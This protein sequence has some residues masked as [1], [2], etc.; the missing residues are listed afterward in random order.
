MKRKWYGVYAFNGFGIYTNYQKLINDRT[1]MRGEHIK[2]FAEQEE[3][4]S[5]ATDGFVEL[6]G[7]NGMDSLLSMV[8]NIDCLRLNYFYFSNNKGEANNAAYNLG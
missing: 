6:N 4:E 3:A 8:S 2:K 7:L 1:Y 5:F